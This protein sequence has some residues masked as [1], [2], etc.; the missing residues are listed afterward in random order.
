MKLIITGDTGEIVAQV[1]NFTGPIPRKGEYIYHPPLRA[2][3]A[4][5]NVMRVKAV[6]HSILARPSHGE[7][8]F[9]GAE[10]IA[11]NE[12]YVEISV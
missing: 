6:T 1:N 8:H 4:P 9:V 2:D 7:K 10:K 5:S 11:G 3:Y 12:P